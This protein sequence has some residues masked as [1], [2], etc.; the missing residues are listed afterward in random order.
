M[1]F[2][3]VLNELERKGLPNENVTFT[4]GCPN[5]YTKHTACIDLLTACPRSLDPFHIVSSYI[6]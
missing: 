3:R 1:Y 5:K 4:T 2:D 6:K